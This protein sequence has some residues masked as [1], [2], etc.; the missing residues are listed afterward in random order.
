[1]QAELIKF[2]Y[3][4]RIALKPLLDLFDHKKRT[5]DTDQWIGFVNSTKSSIILNPEQYIER[6]LPAEF[7]IKDLVEEIFADYLKEEVMQA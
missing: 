7:I 6:D 4:F 1:M 2:K 3:S 5:L